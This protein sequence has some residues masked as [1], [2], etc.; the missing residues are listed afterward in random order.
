LARSYT[1]YAT[2]LKASERIK[3]KKLYSWRRTQKCF[4]DLRLTENFLGLLQN[5]ANVPSAIEN[6]NLEVSSADYGGKRYYLYR[7]ISEV[8]SETHND[9]VPS[10]MLHEDISLSS[11]LWCRLVS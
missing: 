6:S 11:Q 5:L 8:E 3:E 4:S 2:C 7:I 9:L 10:Y 1:Y